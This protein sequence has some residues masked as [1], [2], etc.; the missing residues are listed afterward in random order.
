MD[1]DQLNFQPQIPANA[2]VDLKLSGA[3][4]RY[5]WSIS[6]YNLFN[7]QYYDYAIASASTLGVF[8]AYP[9][10]GRSYLA[11]AGATF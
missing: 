2:T 8:N 1:N 6:V 10:P 4:D 3:Y 11:K 9:L 7:A 5:F